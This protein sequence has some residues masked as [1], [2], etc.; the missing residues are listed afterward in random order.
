MRKVLVLGLCALFV[1]GVASLSMAAG[2]K[3][4]ETHH[5]I[6]GEVVSVD[7][8]AKTITV[9]ETLKSGESKE[10]TFTLA[11]NV[12]VMAQGKKVGIEE[13]QAG[14]SVTVKFTKKEGVD[15]AEELHV[16]KPAP[17]KS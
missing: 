13:L 14:D 16:A 8:T 7:A 15:V 11:D 9:K 10:M 12:K 3:P 4:A 17:K 6:V 5:H 2:K 1:V